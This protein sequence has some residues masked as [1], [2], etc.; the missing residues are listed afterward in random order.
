MLAFLVRCLGVFVQSFVVFVQS[1]V[2]A[3]RQAAGRLQQGQSALFKQG[4]VVGFARAK[5]R[6]H[7]R[8]IAFS[9]DDLRFARVPF[10]FTA[11]VPPLFFWGRSMGVSVA[12]T[13]ITCH[14]MSES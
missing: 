6:R 5:S 14:S 7:Q 8:F 11:I 10:L 1:F 4:E 2:A 12:S 9:H 3:V 13:T